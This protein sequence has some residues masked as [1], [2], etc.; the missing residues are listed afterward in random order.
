MKARI[1]DFKK[2]S[3]TKEWDD[4][5]IENKGRFTQS[6]SWARFESSQNKKVF[7]LVISKGGQRLMEALLITEVFPIGGTMLNLPYGPVFER[8]TSLIDKDKAFNCFLNKIKEIAENEKSIFLK[9]EFQRTTPKIPSQF[10]SGPSLQRR[11]P[12]KT[13]CV[14]LTKSK[15]EL[16]RSFHSQ[17][18]YE[19]RAAQRNDLKLVNYRKNPNKADWQSFLNLLRKTA[20]RKKFTIYSDDHYKK[21]LSALNNNPRLELLLAKHEEKVVGG[22][23]LLFFNQTATYLHAATDYKHR[24]LKTSYF[25]QWEQIKLAKEK[26]YKCLDLWGVNDKKWP[27]VSYFKKGFNGHLKEYPDGKNIIFK[28]FLYKLYKIYKKII[29]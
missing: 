18:R 4:F 14:N 1:L 15:K 29:K 17:T 10:K 9:A 27:G 11:Q 16:L 25:L 19:V 28:P 23:M 26:G 22:T 2:E 13:I 20:R 7:P 24:S 12:Q 5:L 6:S 3:V 21:M 8:S